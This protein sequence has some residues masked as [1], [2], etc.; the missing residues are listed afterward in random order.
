MQAG[1]DR[2][3]SCL[4]VEPTNRRVC[5]GRDPLNPSAWIFKQP[6][7]HF[8]SP[9]PSMNAR[10]LLIGVPNGRPSHA[11]EVVCLCLSLALR[12][13]LF[14]RIPLW[15][16]FQGK[17]TRYHPFWGFSYLTHTH[18]SLQQALDTSQL[19]LTILWACLH[20]ITSRAL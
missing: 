13:G 10:R 16:C 11:R 14:L 18:A 9:G 7:S 15:G 1:R 17:P 12:L 19:Q 5:Q 20:S 6:T 8:R 4:G 3:S 2:F